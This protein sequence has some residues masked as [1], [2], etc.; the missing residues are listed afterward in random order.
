MTTDETE[1]TFIRCP[2][3][4]SLVPAVAS[5]CRMCGELLQNSTPESSVAAEHGGESD[6]FSRKSRV[7]QRTISSPHGE[8]LESEN[9][10]TDHELRVED[11]VEEVREFTS[12]SPVSD[13]NREDDHYRNGESHEEDDDSSSFVEVDTPETYSGFSQRDEYASSGEMR[14]EGRQEYRNENAP[15]SEGQRKRRRRRRRKKRQ[16][17]DVQG[18]SSQPYHSSGLSSGL[19]S[20]QDRS[21]PFQAQD[22]YQDRLPERDS[23]R[24]SQT[25]VMERPMLSRREE[26]S[27]PEQGVQERSVAKQA[28]APL[29]RPLVSGDGVLVGWFI[30][31]GEDNRG[32]ATE[33]RS[34]RYFL[35][36]ERIKE[37]DLVVDNGSLSTPHCL[38]SAS[39][40]KGLRVQDLMSEK[41]TF[42]RRFG[43]ESFTECS[44]PITIKHGDWLR[45]GEYE[46]LVCLVAGKP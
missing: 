29:S 20:G 28:F 39:L 9:S 17:G 15:L 35:S 11:E 34:G 16:D 12:I 27:M 23:Y 3:C 32:V 45:F 13:E 10:E 14:D 40:E 31:Y 4:R 43:E 2:G 46:V 25:S 6:V 41:G 26:R 38:L 44:E 24:T 30:C 8:E 42:L 37:S 33:I 19:G 22:R 5:R 7:R 21:Q 18:G 36:R 1:L